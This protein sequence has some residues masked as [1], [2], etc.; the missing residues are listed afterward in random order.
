MKYRTLGRTGLQVSE[1]AFGCGNIGGLLVRGRPQEQLEAVNRAL[2]LGIN[3]FDTAQFTG[4]V[5]QRRI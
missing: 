2:Q 1:I 4:M 5:S 3:Y